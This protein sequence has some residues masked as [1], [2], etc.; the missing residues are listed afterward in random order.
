MGRS[1]AEAELD[2]AQ[3]VKA[4]K[5][6][7]DPGRFRMVQEIAAA[8]EL[9]C[10]EVAELFDLAQPTVSHHMKILTDAGLLVTRSEGKHHLTSVNR[11][12]LARIATLLPTRLAPSA[13]VRRRPVSSRG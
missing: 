7:A 4:L 8:G 1:A 9:S 10:G 5:A 3:L 6:L 13:K 2:D 12:L 11:E